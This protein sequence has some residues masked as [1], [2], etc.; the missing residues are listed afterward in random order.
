MS[1]ETFVTSDFTVEKTERDSI[2]HTF[3][4]DFSLMPLIVWLLTVNGNNFSAGFIR[5]CTESVSLKYYE[6]MLFTFVIF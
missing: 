5:S 1:S 4:N 3:E 6:E 2:R